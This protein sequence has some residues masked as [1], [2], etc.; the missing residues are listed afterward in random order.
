M[1]RRDFL[2]GLFA[3]CFPVVAGCS[4]TTPPSAT[5]ADAIP[6]EDKTESKN[7]FRNDAPTGDASKPEPETVEQPCAGCAGSGK[8]DG[9]CDTCKNTG[10]CEKCLGSGTQPCRPCGG[11]GQLP[12]RRFNRDCSY[13]NGRGEVECTKCSGKRNCRSCGGKEVKETCPGCRG[14]GAVRVPKT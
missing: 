11:R 12:E 8:V 13:C 1:F 5:D 4:K 10:V 6:T 3:G 14:K 9:V 2:T 7:P